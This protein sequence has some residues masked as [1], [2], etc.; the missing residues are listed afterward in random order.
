MLTNLTPPP[1]CGPII[2]HKKQATDFFYIPTCNWNLRFL[3][4]AVTVHIINK[5]RNQTVIIDHLKINCGQSQTAWNFS[6]DYKAL[7]R[8]SLAPSDGGLQPIS[9]ASFSVFQLLSLNSSSYGMF[10]LWGIATHS[11]M[12]CFWSSWWALQNLH[13]MFP[14]YMYLAF[15]LAFTGIM[16]LLV[17]SIAWHCFLLRW[18][19]YFGLLSLHMVS[20]FFIQYLVLVIMLASSEISCVVICLFIM[21][22]AFP[23]PRLRETC[24]SS[25]LDR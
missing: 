2:L 8:K 18:V 3:S 5:Q 16:L 14:W 20:L 6:P 12:M 4:I 24:Q 9:A 17:I 22:R 7:G 13:D 25:V 23:R 11:V 1:F 15:W 19:M 21:S 10:T